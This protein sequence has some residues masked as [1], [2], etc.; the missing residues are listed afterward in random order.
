MRAKLSFVIPAYNEEHYLGDCLDT[1]IKEVSGRDDVEIVVADNNS[2]DRTIAVA[3]ERKAKFPNLVVV[4]E[5]RRGAN[6]TRQTGFESSHGEIIAFIDAD[7][8]MP[9]GWVATVEREFALHPKVVCVSGP[10]IYYDLSPGIRALVKMFYVWGYVIYL[11]GR[12]IFHRTTII[13]GGNY[14]V[15]RQALEKIGG[16]DVSIVFYGDDTDL[17][18]RLSRIGIVKFSFA[19]PIL[20]SGRRLAKEGTFTMGFRYALNNFWM[21]VFRRPFTMDAKTVR[22]ENGTVYQPENKNRERLIAVVFTSIVVLFFVA[23]VLVAYYVLKAGAF[24]TVSL[25]HLFSG[26]RE[27]AAPISSSP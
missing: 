21:T 3:E 26:A 10:F 15:R 9:A 4:K 22:F 14:A 6:R 2:S 5:T 1:I 11:I 16:Q 27:S 20:T 8:K 24:G 13:Q 23:L 25:A 12:G 17:A 19:M 7:T 18:V